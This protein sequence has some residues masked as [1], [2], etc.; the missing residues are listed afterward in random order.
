MQ[1]PPDLHFINESLTDGSG[2]NN[3]VYN[4]GKFEG[5]VKLDAEHFEYGKPKVLDSSKSFT[6]FGLVSFENPQNYYHIHSER[7]N[8]NYFVDEISKYYEQILLHVQ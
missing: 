1:P 4:N 2:I 5:T 7:N 6:S 8:L 3:T